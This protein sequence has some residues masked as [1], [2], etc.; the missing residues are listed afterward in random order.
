MKLYINRLDAFR[1][2]F[3]IP[4]VGPWALDKYNILMHYNNMFATSMKQKFKHRIYIDLYSAAGFAYIRESRDNIVLT[5]SLIAQNIKDKYDK[6]IYCDND[7]KCIAALRDRVDKYFGTKDC[8]YVIG[9]CNEKVKEIV[10][11]LPIPSTQNTVLTFCVIDPFNLSINFETLSILS[12]Y[13]MDILVLLSWMDGRRN[14][15]QYLKLDNER[16]DKLLGSREWR[17]E[18]GS[19]K[20]E[21]ERWCR[22]LAENFV[23][24]MISLGYLERSRSTMQEIRSSKRNLSLYHLA[25]FS[26]STLAYNYWD[27]ARTKGP[28]QSSFLFLE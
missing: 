27:K 17:K 21:G 5:S 8:C 6:Y 1:D 15:Y 28:D 3:F 10:S 9:D 13:R 20:M 25:F 14:E 2:E 12:K 19:K 23:T 7:P 11:L 18:W 4:E 24:K 22:F 26:K 16:V